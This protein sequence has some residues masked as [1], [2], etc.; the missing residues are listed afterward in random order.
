ML[1]FPAKK[2]YLPDW[3][4]VSS[5]LAKRIVKDDVCTNVNLIDAFSCTSSSWFG[6]LGAEM[7]L[8]VA[9]NVRVPC[10]SDV[11]TN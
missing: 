10:D 3:R 1:V 2:K 9:A 6:S 8:V 4:M 11:L 5:P 7:P